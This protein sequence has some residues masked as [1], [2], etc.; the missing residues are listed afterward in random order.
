MDEERVTIALSA[1][2]RRIISA[3]RDLPAG[4][5]RELLDE[6]LERL[7]EFVRD[8][9]CA[10]LQADGAPC[11]SP[12]SDCEQCARLKEILSGLRSRLR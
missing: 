8:P 9:H 4:Q 12:A 1:K 2:E 7:V 6:V 3:L 11:T 5:P 10:E